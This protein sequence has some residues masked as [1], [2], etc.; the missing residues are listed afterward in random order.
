MNTWK[1]LEQ[2]LTERTG[3]SPWDR[4]KQISDG[5][6][7]DDVTVVAKNAHLDLEPHDHEDIYEGAEINK[8]H[9]S[10]LAQDAAYKIVNILGTSDAVLGQQV[11]TKMPAIK[12]VI[13]ELI[14][15]IL[16]EEAGSNEMSEAPVDFKK[17]FK[18][19]RDRVV[20]LGGRA[21]DLEYEKGPKKQKDPT[22]IRAGGPEDDP[23]KN[24]TNAERYDSKMGTYYVSKQRDSRYEAIYVSKDK[25]KVTDLGNAM[26]RKGAVD[27]VLTHHDKAQGGLG[28][29]AEEEMM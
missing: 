16:E 9:V 27:S 4:A 11:K 12:T 13:E 25:K 5:M 23:M 8:Q 3:G 15:E 20:K 6:D 17:S 28:E 24:A 10:T 22:K 14:I 21:D 29:C 1:I 19:A 2:K 26:D 7:E 18:N